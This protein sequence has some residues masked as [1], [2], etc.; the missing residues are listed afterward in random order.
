MEVQVQAAP[1]CPLHDL[2]NNGHGN[3]QWLPLLLTS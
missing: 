1:V 2:S 3:S